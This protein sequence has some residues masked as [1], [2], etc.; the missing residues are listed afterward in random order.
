MANFFAQAHNCMY[1]FTVITMANT[2]T[3]GMNAILMNTHKGANPQFCDGTTDNIL[4]FRL[5]G[6]YGK[7]QPTNDFP[8]YTARSVPAIYTITTDLKSYL[9][10]KSI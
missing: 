10:N 1:N 9:E 4:R 5:T 8:Y 2:V 7:P 6:R 3:E